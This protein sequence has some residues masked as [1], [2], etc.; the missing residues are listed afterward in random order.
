MGTYGGKGQGFR[1]Y[2]TMRRSV[3]FSQCKGEVTKSDLCW[4]VLFELLFGE[5]IVGGMRQSIGGK[6]GSSKTDY[7]DGLGKMSWSHGQR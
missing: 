5:W 3:D 2:E 7:H 4:K 1:V 6:H